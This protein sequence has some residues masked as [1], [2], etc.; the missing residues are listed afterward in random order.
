MK[1]KTRLNLLIDIPREIRDQ[2]YEN[3][4][5]TPYNCVTYRCTRKDTYQIL[6]YDPQNDE[7]ISDSPLLTLGLLSTCVQVYREAS[8]S[9]WKINSLGLWPADLLFSMRSLREDVFTR[10]QSIQ[11]NLDLIDPDDLKFAAVLFSRMGAWSGMR[12]EART[13]AGSAWGSLKTVQLNPMRTEARKMD[14]KWMQRVAE[15]MHLRWESEELIA[16]E[17]GD[18]DESWGLYTEW[19][20]LFR[21]AGTPGNEAYLGDRVKR[22]VNVNTA[23]DG[24]TYREQ[25]RWVNKLRHGADVRE[26]EQVM[27]DLN[28]NFGG[29]LWAN[30]KLCYKEKK[31]LK[32]VFEVKPVEAEPLVE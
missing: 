30:G 32:R 3:A 4:F 25:G 26:M 16:G 11:V 21:K 15:A 17:N 28:H 6:P 24:W 13:G 19:M 22:V 14:V 23:W 27:T 29:E 8:I 31:R 10:I 5:Q 9:L 7:C 2:I 12:E 20:E 18:A 1:T